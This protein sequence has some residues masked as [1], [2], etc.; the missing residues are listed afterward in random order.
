[1]GHS[2]LCK[3][4]TPISAPFLGRGSHE[5]PWSTLFPAE[6]VQVPGGG[7]AGAPG[8][9]SITD[10]L[11]RWPAKVL[12]N[13]VQ[14]AGRGRIRLSTHITKRKG[15]LHKEGIRAAGVFCCQRI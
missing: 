13:A 6:G 9:L 5:L 8:L 15:T 2:C 1:M 7:S 3:K 14:G 4:R 12:G 11:S 10:L